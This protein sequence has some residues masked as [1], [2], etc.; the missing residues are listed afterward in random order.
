MSVP[1]EPKAAFRKS[2][3]CRHLE[4]NL[5]LHSADWQTQVAHDSKRLVPTN[6]EKALF[7]HL[8]SPMETTISAIVFFWMPTDTQ[9][10]PARDPK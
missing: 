8:S 1:L 9:I 10:T 2:R 5:A 3:F 7:E 4:A 6:R